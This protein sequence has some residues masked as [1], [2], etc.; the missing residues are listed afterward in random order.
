M[1][2]LAPGPFP[3]P[4]ICCDAVLVDCWQSCEPNRIQYLI[5]ETTMLQNYDRTQLN[6]FGIRHSVKAHAWGDR[7][8]TRS[9][10]LLLPMMLMLVLRLLL[11]YA[12]AY[13]SEVS[14]PLVISFHLQD[15]LLQLHV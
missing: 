7:L 8:L 14:C 4:A 3:G 2:G 15:L 13:M 11:K 10:L 1:Q 9:G 5:D 6:V 12:L